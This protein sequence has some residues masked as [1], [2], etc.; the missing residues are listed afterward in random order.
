MRRCP[1]CIRI[2]C[3]FS[4]C[5]AAAYP[6][7]AQSPADSPAVILTKL[8]PPVY[9]PIALTAAVH[10]EVEVVVQVRKDGSVASTEVVGRQTLLDRASLISAQ[11]S[12]FQCVNCVEEL[13]AFH[14]LYT[15]RIEFAQPPL[16]C[17]AP[18]DCDRSTPARPTESSQSENHVTVIG[19][20]LQT[21]ICE[22][23]KKI[24]AVRCL[25]LWKCGLG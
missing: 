13:T 3:L 5:L 18:D 6:G 23:R 9:P 22:Y 15:F 24:R 7:L 8:S 19:H 2:L 25:Y 21:C 17:N 4:V 10:G 1:C 16:S 20:P 12:Q 11:Q 14:L